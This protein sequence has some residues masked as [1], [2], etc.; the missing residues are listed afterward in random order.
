MV[1]ALADPANWTP[2]DHAKAARL[3]SLLV[4]AERRY[5]RRAKAYEQGRRSTELVD[6]QRLALLLVDADR[7][8]RDL[9]KV[10]L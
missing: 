8:V 7:L 10:R 9:A 1:S 3:A 2:R 6:T 5:S 4:R